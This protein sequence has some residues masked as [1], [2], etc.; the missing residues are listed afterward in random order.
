MQKHTPFQTFLFGINRLVFQEKPGKYEVSGQ[1]KAVKPTQAEDIEALEQAGGKAIRL[2]HLDKNLFDTREAKAEKPDTLQPRTME[3]A[4]NWL[5]AQQVL[6]DSGMDPSKEFLALIGLKKPTNDPLFSFGKEKIVAAV[7]ALQKKVRAVDDGV[8]G[9]ATYLAVLNK[10]PD[11]YADARSAALGVKPETKIV[12]EL[13]SSKRKERKVP[14]LGALGYEPKSLLAAAERHGGP[15]VRYE[16]SE[17]KLV[18]AEWRKAKREKESIGE[19]LDTAKKAGGTDTTML[20]RQYAAAEKA[21]ATALEKG[22]RA[23]RDADLKRK[24]GVAGAN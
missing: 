9:R 1:L 7:K 19:K 18:R 4:R 2:A 8:F 15:N 20:E 14:D 12:A 13:D 6:I 24:G 23:K 11:K 22:A 5:K 17:E 16:S 21:E 10:Y 3:E